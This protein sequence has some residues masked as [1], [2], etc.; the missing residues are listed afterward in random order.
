MIKEAC[1]KTEI[2]KSAV[3][4]QRYKLIVHF[5][6]GNSHTRVGGL[7]CFVSELNKSANKNTRKYP[8]ST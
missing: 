3:S 2:S 8:S 7:K 5:Q 4:L 6:S 1:K